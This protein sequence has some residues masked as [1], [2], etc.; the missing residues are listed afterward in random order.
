M[1]QRK[2]YT[3]V[4]ACV[5]EIVTGALDSADL[6]GIVTSA[7]P[8]ELEALLSPKY[9]GMNDPAGRKYARRNTERSVLQMVSEIEGL[10][11]DSDIDRTLDVLREQ[12]GTW[13]SHAPLDPA[14]VVQCPAVARRLIE[15]GKIVTLQGERFGFKEG[16]LTIISPADPE[17]AKI[18]QCVADQKLAGNDKPVYDYA[19][20][21][22]KRFK[23]REAQMPDNVV[24]L[25]SDMDLIAV[26]FAAAARIAAENIVDPEKVICVYSDVTDIERREGETQENVRQRFSD[27]VG[28]MFNQLA[29]SNVLQGS[30]RAQE[31]KI[32]KAAH[33][34]AMR[35]W[36]AGVV[37]QRRVS[38]RGQNPHVD[39]HGLS[40]QFSFYHA[41]THRPVHTPG[42]DRRTD[43][44]PGPSRVAPAIAA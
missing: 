24:Q 16:T 19:D 7:S 33:T 8:A 20:L 40:L 35:W 5:P 29:H 30:E 6:A 22:G 37:R 41:A 27:A 44:G 14:I 39:D 3:R 10:I 2:V 26:D 42:A 43:Y 18:A 36:D 15:D 13:A 31:E 32:A 34:I 17:L 9:A 11:N 38:Q 4:G 21:T 1:G 28:T 25:A 23:P 12:V